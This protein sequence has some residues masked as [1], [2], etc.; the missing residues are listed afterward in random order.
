[1]CRGGMLVAAREG[2]RRSRRRHR[3]R[4]AAA[5]WLWAV[6]GRWSVGGELAKKKIESWRE[7][8]KASHKMPKTLHDCLLFLLLRASMHEA[9]DA[10]H[11]DQQR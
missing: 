5:G 8:A 6:G 3:R 9:A 10:D 11:A 1:M 7:L 2:G 4:F